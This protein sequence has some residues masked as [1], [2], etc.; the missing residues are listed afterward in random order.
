MLD[1]IRRHQKW[2]LVLII[3]LVVPSFVFLGVANYQGLL[4]NDAPLAQ[5]KEQKITRDQFNMDWRERLNQ[6]RIQEGN[7]FDISQVDV[8]QN[9]RAFLEQMINSRVLHEQVVSAHYSATDEMVRQAI[10]QDPQFHEDGRFS[11]Q[12]YSD[13]LQRVGIDANM[14]QN[15]IRYTLA[16]E[17]VAQP[18]MKS[19]TIPSQV[20]EAVVSSLLQERSVRLRLFEASSYFTDNE[21]TEAEAKA[22]YDANKNSLEV[23]SH[24]DAQYI[25][26]NEEAAVNAVP[27]PTETELEQYYE[28]NKSRYTREERRSINH[29]QL[30]LPAGASAEQVAETEQKAAE[31]IE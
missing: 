24:T 28:S 21:P 18:V 5:I 4:S 15:S 16:L 30:N 27:V 6:L 9:R 26:L 1:F 22:W 23:P 7:Q 12:K 31:I 20:E 25:I 14:Y 11:V 19:L 29:I 10:A 2:M 8:P 13:F 3:V 17:Q